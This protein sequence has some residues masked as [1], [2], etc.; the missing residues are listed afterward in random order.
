MTDADSP[1]NRVHP[2]EPS[3][4][5]TARVP[6]PPGPVADDVDEPDEYDEA[7]RE[8]ADELRR[9]VLRKSIRRARARRRGSGTIWSWM[10]MFGLVGWTVAVPTL[11]GIALGVFLDDRTDNSISFTI[12]FL[13]VGAAV[14]VTMAWYW[15]RR[16][17]EGDDGP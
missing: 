14:G 6:P 1:R 13:V 5:G 2:E 4:D 16:E 3:E 10:G 17:S 11:L 7:A 12:T 9:I 15:V 8:R